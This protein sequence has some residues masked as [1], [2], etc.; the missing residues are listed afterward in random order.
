MYSV[1]TDYLE[2]EIESWNL[3]KVKLRFFEL[4]VIRDL[5]TVG[6]ELSVVMEHQD[7]EFL[8]EA[9]I[10]AE[11]AQSLDKETINRLRHIQLLTY[12]DDP[13]LDV[14]CARLE[15]HRKGQPPISY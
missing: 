13:G 11:K 2:L 9:K 14:L 7:S 4:G 5:G 12:E 15:V 1:T 6:L 10:L 8:H 3:K